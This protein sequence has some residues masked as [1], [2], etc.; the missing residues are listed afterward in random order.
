MTALSDLE[1]IKR[2]SRHLRGTLRESL[3]DPVTGALRPDDVQLLKFHGGY[4]QDDRDSREARRRAKLEPAY[5]FMLRL[6]L[7]GGVLTPAQWLAMDSVAGH[8][9]TRGLRLTTRQTIQLHGIDKRE[10]RTAVQAIH[11]AG[12]DTIAAC[13]DVNRNVV[14][15]IN[16]LLSR[17]HAAVYAQAAALSLHLL[18][19][20][21]AWYETWLNEVPGAGDESEPLLSDTYLPRKF[22]FG[23]AIP[24]DN[25]IDVY[26][27]DVGL[28][29]IVE[30]DELAGYDVLVGGGMGASHGDPKTC[31]VM[32]SPIGFITPDQV[33]TLAEAVL[34]TQRDFG[35]RNERKHARLKY[36]IDDRGLDWF[37]QEVE[38]R[39]GFRLQAAHR[40][41]FTERGDPFGW[42]EGEDGRWHLGLR[43]PA[44]RI[45]DEDDVLRKTGM[46][47]LVEL[48]AEAAPD[49]QIRLTPNQNLLLA[50]VPTELRAHVDA[51][52]AEHGLNLHH[53]ATRLRLD[54]LA[55]VALP[56]CGLAMA[57]AERYLPALLD[58]LQALL[59]RHGLHDEPIGLRVSGCPN[60]CSRPYLAEIALIGKA[61]G[62]Y[63]LMLGGDHRGQ[64]MNT[65]Y[66]EN[67][68]ETEI[69][70]VLDALFARFATE[71]ESGERF[72]DFL[73]RVGVV[74]APAPREAAA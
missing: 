50:G 33:K 16:P 73:V 37:K 68:I 44:G 74:V 4:Q 32:A 62:R 66:R 48:L 60:G 25:D 10:L 11:A 21:R 58:Q 13:G 24:P 45:R 49:V 15:A 2:E 8:F 27:Q 56:T 9:A 1:R 52:T 54:A 29:A 17:L 14:V 57:E 47:A 53:H 59:D 35:D 26:A 3:A 28:I 23:F 43:I 12:L 71:R 20:S 6:R 65:L 36:T 42:R 18:P 22:K 69:L 7:P 34:T 38:Q 39:T 63:N 55:C 51:L 40:S 61:P 72:G 64:R 67:I 31:P 70:A 19:R 30:G 41:T 46:R 5:G